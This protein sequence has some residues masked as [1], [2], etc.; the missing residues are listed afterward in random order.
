M[1]KM[2]SYF[3]DFT[4]KARI[5]PAGIAVI[6][7][8][9]YGVYKSII[10]KNLF[11]GTMYYIVLIFVLSLLGYI[12]RNLGKNFEKKMFKK[13]GAMPTTLLLMFSDNIIDT[14]TKIRY[15]KKLNDKIPDLELPMSIEEERKYYVKPIYDSSINWLRTYANRN[16][17][18]YPLVLQ[19]L[20]KYNFWRNLY[21][22]KYISIAF[23]SL[24][25]IREILIMDGF[26]LKDIIYQPYPQYI[27]IIIL[28]F[29]IILM[30][31]FVTK[32]NVKE[33]AFEYA[34][35]LLEV[36]EDL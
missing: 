8:V 33:R 17:E 16:S 18:K 14:N 32:K 28:L 34:K 12:T 22:I 31:F 19:E 6:P 26:D 21:G 29:S 1:E 20:I 10:Y 24:I 11:E 7:L 2:K 35:A 13:L 27:S 23:Y 25:G 3:G 9:I 36:C 15:H 30:I 5:M 4:L